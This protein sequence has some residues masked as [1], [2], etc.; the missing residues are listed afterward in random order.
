MSDLKNNLLLAVP[1]GELV[2]IERS[3]LRHSID[4]TLKFS[5]IIPTFNESQNIPRSSPDFK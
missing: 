2:I 4:R 5:L 3:S 1:T